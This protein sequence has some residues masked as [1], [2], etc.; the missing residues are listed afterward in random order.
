[1]NNYLLPLQ[2]LKAQDAAL[3]DS[4]EKDDANITDGGGKR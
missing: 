3:S 2:S 1:M 4:E